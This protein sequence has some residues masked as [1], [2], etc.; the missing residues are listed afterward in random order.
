MALAPAMTGPAE[1]PAPG[2][3][4]TA[5]QPWPKRSTAWIAVSI[6]AFILMFAELERGIFTLLV[7]PIKRDLHLSDTQMSLILGFSLVVFY[8]VVSIPLSRFVDTMKR[9]VILSIGIAI[10]ATMTAACGLANSFAQLFLCRVLV[11]AGGAV[12]G[13]GTYSLMADYFPREKLP[14]AIA[15]LQIGY[16][17]GGSFALVFGGML[18]GALSKQPTFNLPIVGTVHSWQ[19]VLMAVGLPGLLVA[20]IMRAVPEPPR[21]GRI[22]TTNKT[23]PFRTVAAILGKNW[24]VYAPL[25]LGLSFSA[26]ESLGIRS[27]APVFFQRTYGWDAQQTGA[28]L[29]TAQLIGWPIGLAFGTWLTERLSRHHNDANLRVVVVAY[30]LTAPCAILGPLMPNP[31]LAVVLSAASGAFGMASAVPINAALQSV[32]PNEMRGQVTALFLF[33]FAVIGGGLG[34]TFIALIT[35]YVLRDEQL[36]RYAMSGSAAV[37]TP[38]AT[39]VIWLGLGRYGQAIGEVKERERLGL[40]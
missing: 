38:L 21:R 1:I 28:V 24:R 35:D 31:W 26:V 20:L 14:R 12:H 17:G 29:G 6:F 13:P 27:W 10:G 34:P 8:A 3:D 5:V 19:A 25:F 2:D 36:I 40:A 15:V 9:N 39:L 11:G 4:T 16:I 23:I 22:S 30:A 7:T 33:I 32:T 18:I 37:M